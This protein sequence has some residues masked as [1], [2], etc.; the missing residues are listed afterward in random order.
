MPIVL[1]SRYRPATTTDAPKPNPVL[2]GSSANC[3]MMMNAEYMPAPS[4]NA[5]ALAVQTPRIR[6]IV[7]SISG[8][9]LR[10]STAIQQAP[11]A[12]PAASSPSVFG[13]PQPQVV[14]SL[15]ASR[16]ADMLIVISVAAVQLILPG[17]RTGDSGMNRHVKK[18][19]TTVNASG[20]QNSQC[21]LRYLTISPEP[22]M[23][24]PLPTPRIADSRP[25]LPATRSRGNSSRTIP[26]AS[27]KMPPAAP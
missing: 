27:G 18:A 2:V 5:A 22:T 21:Q 26:K 13:D 8:V 15:I 17:A 12:I 10:T 25:M 3:G 11:T 1:G 14:V 4:R 24:S 19:A 6:I 7:M 20:I 9:A 23:P 16:I